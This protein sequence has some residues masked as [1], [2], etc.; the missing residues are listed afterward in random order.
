[1][2]FRAVSPLVRFVGESSTLEVSETALTGAEPLDVA[3]T[4]GV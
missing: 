1:M 3:V 2:T 4:V